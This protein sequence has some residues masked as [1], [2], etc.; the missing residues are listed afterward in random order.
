MRA[1]IRRIGEITDAEGLVY[2]DRYMDC[3][4]YEPGLGYY[5]RGRPPIGHAGDFVTL[6]ETTP[7]FAESLAR[8]FAPLYAGGLERTLVEIGPG[9]GGLA[10]QL[11]L[12]LER[13]GTPLDQCILVEPDPA[14]WSLQQS[15][16]AGPRK[17]SRTH[18]EWCPD[19]PTKWEGIVVLNE[20]VDAFP[21]ARVEK[22]R[23]GWFEW[24]VALRSGQPVFEPMSLRASVG[25]EL[26]GIEA[27]LGPLPEGYRTECRPGLATRLGTLLTGCTRGYACII[28]Y[29]YSRRHYYHPDRGMGTLQCFFRQ[30]VHD[31]PLHAPGVEDLTA[32]VDFTRLA[33][34]V[35]ASG[36]ELAGYAP[37][38]PFVL[39]TGL[40]D[41]GS[42]D[43][44][45][46]S[47]WVRQVLRLTGP[48][49][50]G[51][52]FKVM[53]LARGK[54]PPVAVFASCDQSERL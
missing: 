49:E 20:I 28:D 7:L 6:P 21:V 17:Q 46:Q 5:R 35:D 33:E 32:M 24:G 15:W 11:T 39:A 41:G 29:G 36:F 44:A 54:V 34:A 52:L 3:A 27:L 43:A 1:M 12:A 37:L 42:P 48:H 19:P 4:L 22:G 25:D 16:L 38:A 18:F 14:A 8:V 2:F 30:L 13:A 50:A 40:I 51:E 10:G 23:S 31:D 47:D 9:T 53:M 45:R 26:A